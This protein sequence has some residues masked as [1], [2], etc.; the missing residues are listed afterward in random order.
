[1]NI[2]IF[3]ASGRTGQ[4]VV[5][6]AL[7]LGHTVTAVVRSPER[8][9]IRY[10]RLRVA[11]GD[12]LAPGS[13]AVA[14][15]GQDAVV[16]ALGS[17]GGLQALRPTRFHTDTAR[18]IVDAMSRQ[19]IRRFVGITSVGVEHDPTTPLWYRT[20]LQPL[21]RHKYG[22]MAGMEQVVKESGLDWTIVRPVRLTNGPLTQHYRVAEG[23]VRNGTAISRADVADLI[24]RLLGDARDAQK[25]V[26]VSY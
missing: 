7:A 26:A 10:P 14:L 23:T 5:L 4:H 2:A 3:G 12:A 24:Q 22:D 17:G 16:S 13:F 19:G 1:M 25:A 15:A 11:A 8:F 6:Q 18:N 20:I 21:L 9:A